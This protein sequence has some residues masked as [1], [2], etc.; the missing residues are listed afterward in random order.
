MTMLVGWT[1]DSSIAA[2]RAGRLLQQCPDRELADVHDAACV[3]WPRASSKPTTHFLRELSRDEETGEAFWGVFFGLSFFSPL[4]GAAVGRAPNRLSGW[5]ADL[6]IDDTFVNR[7][8]DTVTPGTS[9]LF[10]L[11]SDGIVD[12][13]GDALRPGHP[14]NVLAS[15]LNGVHDLGAP[16]TA[17]GTE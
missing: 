15:R 11:G 4:M 14:V 17:G 7:V 16:Q 10:V 13:L 9:A 3:S 1:F 12:E 2:E 6:G 5:L 8:R